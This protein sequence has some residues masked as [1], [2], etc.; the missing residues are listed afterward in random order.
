MGW[1]NRKIIIKFA[2][3]YGEAAHK[4]CAN[5]ELAPELLYAGKENADIY[6]WHVIIMDYVDGEPLCNIFSFN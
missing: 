1:T 3:Q 6:K 2:K 5:D 4:L